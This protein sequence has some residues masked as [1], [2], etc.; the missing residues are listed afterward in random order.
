MPVIFSVSLHCVA[1]SL[2][3]RTQTI[4]FSIISF[5]SRRTKAVSIWNINDGEISVF[6]EK[7][8]FFEPFD[9]CTSSEHT[10]EFQPFWAHLSSGG[11]SKSLASVRYKWFWLLSLLVLAMLYLIWCSRDTHTFT[12]SAKKEEEKEG[13]RQRIGR[14]DDNHFIPK[15]SQN[16]LINDVY[17]RRAGWSEI[18]RMLSSCALLIKYQIMFKMKNFFPDSMCAA[19]SERGQQ[20]KIHFDKSART[21]F[22]NID[23]RLPP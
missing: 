10:S 23:T 20:E 1:H 15:S 14:Y 17:L 22:A 7:M 9:V 4:F 5:W 3:E 16:I 12:Q 19:Q 13:E 8:S 18:H 11:S 21:L 6:V 2:V